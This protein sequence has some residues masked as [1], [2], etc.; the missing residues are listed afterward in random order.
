MMLQTLELTVDAPE[1]VMMSSLF[2][3]LLL[4]SPSS[5]KS[6]SRPNAALMP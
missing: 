3:V 4:E 2:D 5:A 1:K 6:I